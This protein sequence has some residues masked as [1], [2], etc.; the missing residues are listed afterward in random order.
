MSQ[1]VEQHTLCILFEWL[2]W[3]SWICVLGSQLCA[4][5]VYPMRAS[6]TKF[7]FQHRKKGTLQAVLSLKKYINKLE[8]EISPCSCGVELLKSDLSKSDL[9]TVLE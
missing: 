7:I 9:E 2:K 4:A 6:G 5:C 8:G 1:D 3:D